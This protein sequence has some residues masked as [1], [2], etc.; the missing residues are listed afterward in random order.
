MALKKRII[1]LPQTTA[2][3]NSGSPIAW[4][5]SS[6]LPT[7]TAT[8]KL[9]KPATPAS[10]TNPS[11][12]TPWTTVK[13]FSDNMTKP[14]GVG[15]V[16][17][18]AT[19]KPAQTPQG[20][21]IGQNVDGSYIY[22]QDA[23]NMRNDITRKSSSAEKFWWQWWWSWTP[24]DQT[25][26]PDQKTTGIASPKP[27]F[28]WSLYDP[29]NYLGSGKTKDEFTAMSVADQTNLINQ[30]V[31]N[32]EE[33]QAILNQVKTYAEN[34]AQQEYLNKQNAIRTGID[35]SQTTTAEIQASQ[36]IREAQTNLDNMKQNLGF[37]GTWGRPMKSATAIE[38]ASRM[39]MQSEQTFQELKN[40]ESQAKTMREAGLQMNAN[41]YEEQMRQLQ[42]QLTDSVDASIIQAMQWFDSEAA[43]ASIDS[44]KKLFDLQQ[45][46][47]D[48][49]DT[50]V[51]GIT[52]RQVNEMKNLQ[53]RYA[54]YAKQFAEDLKKRQTQQAEFIKNKN[55]LNE[56]MSK[57]LWYYVDWNGSPLQ[58]T[59]GKVIEYKD[60]ADKPI[61][62]WNTWKVAYFNTDANGN[63]VVEIKQLFT[64]EKKAPNI[65]K[66]WVWA[67]WEDIYG[68]Y[69]SA[70]GQVKTVS[71]PAMTWWLWD[72]RN[73]AS[74]FP[75]QAR[76][77]NNNPAGIT[78][79]AYFDNPKPWTTA[80]ALQQ[81]GVSFEK[82]TPRPRNEW[83]NYVAFP[84]MEDWLAAQRIMM[85][86]TYGNTTVW[87]MLAK[88]V[89]T[90]EWPRY[91]QQVASMA[92]VD[93][94]AIV[95]QL[96][97]QQLQTLQMA[98]IQKESPWLAKILQ[99]QTQQ[100]NQEPKQSDFP[101]YT[102][103]IENG[104][105]PAWMKDWTSKAESFKQQALDWYI[106]GKEQ[107]FNW[108]WLTISN[109]TAFASAV[110]DASKIKEVNKAVLT[111]PKFKDTMD[112]LISLEKEYWTEN[113]PTQAKQTMNML[114]KDAQ[115]QAKEIYNLWVLNWPDLSLMESIIPNP[116]SWSA[117]WPQILWWVS[118]NEMLKSAKDKVLWNAYAQAR[119][120]W[121]SPM[122]QTTWTLSW[123][124]NRLKK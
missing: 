35:Q 3:T 45:K 7:D 100:K 84:T 36:R 60:E 96:S 6:M 23:K 46:Y 114:V 122:W 32:V 50:S 93:V 8:V 101:Q 21:P 66:V 80:Y 73:L 16:K 12:L 103:Y 78:W 87:N 102:S 34:K 51:E 41:Q 13:S 9:P 20:N 119:T 111:L 11:S 58:T 4:G 81:A 104:K 124:T 113:R 99:Q 70:T 14:I 59:D 69:D 117:L 118:Y 55:T 49:V 75:W 31:Q 109:P 67:D 18:P 52:N 97:D 121:L 48:M 38:W 44:P 72:M 68:Y 43:L 65:E 91:A 56:K 53:T 89:W 1:G 106:K 92:G 37:L 82:G 10:V 47:L 115:L 77:K 112:Q 24:I 120:I 95:N 54:D 116:T 61:I 22:E 28:S 108:A 57:A 29:N 107:E 79:D 83:G 90:G 123:W 26:P 76:A 110:T 63:Q 2:T 27:E 64:P 85:T 40:L 19:P 86:Q 98:K 94:N 42:K 17:Q 25:M 62:D 105:L 88:W 33:R 74:Q 15:E 5:T 30:A 71:T 39:L